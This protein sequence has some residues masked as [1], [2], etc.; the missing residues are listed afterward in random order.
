MNAFALFPESCEQQPHEPRDWERRITIAGLYHAILLYAPLLL[1]RT[2]KRLT[3][4][5]SNTCNPKKIVRGPFPNLD[6][7]IAWTT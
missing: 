3:I 2:V 1:T 4:N 6:V 7:L 5:F